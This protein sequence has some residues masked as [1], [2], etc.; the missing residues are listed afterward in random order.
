MIGQQTKD[1]NN[2]QEKDTV[3]AEDWLSQT[4]REIGNR[5]QKED[6]RRK[7]LYQEAQLMVEDPVLTDVLRQS[8]LEQNE[9]NVE[10]ATPSCTPKVAAMTREGKTVEDLA[11]SWVETANA[12]VDLG[13]NRELEWKTS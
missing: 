2:E 9:E 4:G 10:E 7:A 13:K 5:V 12:D 11:T 1:S 3:L 8:E 6:S